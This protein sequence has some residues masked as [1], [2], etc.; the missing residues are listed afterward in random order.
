MVCLGEEPS[1]LILTAS[2]CLRHDSAMAIDRSGMWWTGENLDDLSAY[3]RELCADSYPADQVRHCR[4]S[5]CD[6]IVFGLRADRNE[7]TARRTC[8]TCGAKQFIAD[9]RDHWAD[10]SP[11]TW[12]CVCGCRD[13]NLAVAYSLFDESGDVRWITV[14]QRCTGCGVMGSYVDWKV[15]YGPSG[16]LLDQA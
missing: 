1:I 4:C 6:G 3:L 2:G 8:R 13:A 12:K 7:G 11:R 15:A 5:Q 9:S 14:G 10:C 16:H